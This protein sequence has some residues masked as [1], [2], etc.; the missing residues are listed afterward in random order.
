MI[1]SIFLILMLCLLPSHACGTQ[2][3]RGEGLSFVEHPASAPFPYDGPYDDTGK[4]FFD[5]IDPNTGIRSHTNRYG[6]RFP[7]AE[8]YDDSSVFFHIPP[9]F[10][11]EKPFM[12]LVF[13]HGLES[14]ITKT[15][16]DYKISEQVDASG[17]NVILI[18]PQL[19]KNAA[20]SSPGKFF[21]QNAFGT[22]MAE[23]A[24]IL[25]RRIGEQYRPALRAAPVLISAFSGGYK[26]AAYVLDRGGE[27]RRIRGVFLIDA[28]YE[29]LEKFEKWIIDGA[30][31]RSFVVLYTRGTEKNT[32]ELADRL[33]GDGIKA[34]WTWPASL[35]AG[36]VN[37]IQS[38]NE[39]F[40]VPLLGPPDH[41]LSHFLNIL[42]EESAAK[43]RSN[44]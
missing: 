11:P 28:L 31:H 4:C 25:D 22:F 9:H 29:D 30:G 33:A 17:K 23:A 13:F 41:P 21:G 42:S 16:R 36:K 6:A 32:Y 20:D 26:A 43:A 39:H 44:P 2:D 35:Y 10:S 34:D 14:D 40:M 7:E 19:A 37:L 24:A 12:L 8:H 27:G 18:M 5:A 3:E 38:S 1:S 15:E